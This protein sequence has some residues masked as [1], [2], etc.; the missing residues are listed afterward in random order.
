MT[1]VPVLWVTGIPPDSARRLHPSQHF[2]EHSD[3]DADQ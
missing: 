3:D 2:R 1:A